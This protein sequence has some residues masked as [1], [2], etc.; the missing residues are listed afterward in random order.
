MSQLTSH[1]KYSKSHEWL[2]IEPDGSVVMGITDYAQDSLGDIVYVDLPQVG[3]E[4]DAACEIVVIESVKA[5]SD[6]YAPVSGQVV[7]INSILWDEPG[8][9]NSS[10]YE[11]G[12]LVR[13]KTR[14]AESIEDLLDEE[15]YLTLIEE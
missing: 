13:L 2:R 9:V 12:W 1:L 15:Q 8:R 3:D 10:P 4:V 14:E 5:A 11:D 6:I 7:E